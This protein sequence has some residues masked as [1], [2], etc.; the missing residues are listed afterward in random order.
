MK[1][2]EI[3]R[4][5]F[6]SKVG[7]GVSATIM[8]GKEIS[9]LVNT[10]TAEAGGVSNLKIL[11]QLISMFGLSTVGEF[12]VFN[13]GET[14]F[15]D[16][17]SRQER[18]DLAEKILQLPEKEVEP[19]A[20]AHWEHDRRHFRELDENDPVYIINRYF[21]LNELIRLH[22]ID[23]AKWASKLIGRKLDYL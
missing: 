2:A 15:V 21:V 14:T 17:L 7:A 18:K 8:P 5:G 6:L 12:F 9:A 4:R 3:S 10:F 23:I 1:L 13:T 11:S 22:D 20:L 19:E 16:V